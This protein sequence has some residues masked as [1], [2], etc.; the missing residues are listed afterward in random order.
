MMTR[1]GQSGQVIITNYLNGQ[2]RGQHAP[3]GQRPD[4]G[5]AYHPHHDHHPHLLPSL[6]QVRVVSGPLR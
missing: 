1:Y 4:G 5:H 6:R 2:D 3:P